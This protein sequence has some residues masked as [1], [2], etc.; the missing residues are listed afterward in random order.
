M[1]SNM[2]A[3]PVL[4]IGS[5][6]DP[7][8]TLVKNEKTGALSGRRQTRAVSPF[9]SIFTVT[10]CSKEARSWAEQNVAKTRTRVASLI[11]R[12]IERS[13]ERRVGKE[14][15]KQMGQGE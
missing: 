15:R 6:T 11:A 8:S 3:R 12:D 2:C 5:C 1:C 9:G 13:E 7:T 10:R 4:P 14:R